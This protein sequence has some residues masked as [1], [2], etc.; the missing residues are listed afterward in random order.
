MV[1]IIIAENGPK[2][3]NFHTVFIEDRILSSFS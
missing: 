1:L 3:Y 2:K